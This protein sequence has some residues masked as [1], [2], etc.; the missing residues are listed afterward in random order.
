MP[1]QQ[2][3]IFPTPAKWFIPLRGAL[4]G[5]APRTPPARRALFGDNLNVFPGVNAEDFS[6]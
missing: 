6:T 4:P 1:T 5:E 2:R 3:T